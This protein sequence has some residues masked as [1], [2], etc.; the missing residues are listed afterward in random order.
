MYQG[1]LSQIWLRLQSDPTFAARLRTDFAG[2]LSTEGYLAALP[3][4][5]LPTVYR[6][7]LALQHTDPDS[8]GHEG[9][10]GDDAPIPDR[11]LS[12]GWAAARAPS[13]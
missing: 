13:A 1:I 8:P 2:V 9:E 6:W 7:H 12:A 10:R 3:I 4:G 11:T 5:D